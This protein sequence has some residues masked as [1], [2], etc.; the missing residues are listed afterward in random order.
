M[1]L[2]Y[3]EKI[4]IKNPGKKFKI[5]RIYWSKQNEVK[6]LSIRRE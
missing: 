2:E 1:H 4:G 3:N 6:L 5:K